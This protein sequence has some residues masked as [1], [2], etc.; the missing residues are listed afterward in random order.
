MLLFVSRFSF[1]EHFLLIYFPPRMPLAV[2]R[3][4][5]YCLL[6]MF[7]SLPS[8]ERA[9]RTTKHGFRV[10]LH[11]CHLHGEFFF[12]SRFAEILVSRT[13]ESHIVRCSRRG[14]RPQHR[15]TIT[16]DAMRWKEENTFSWSKP[17][18]SNRAEILKLVILLSTVSDVAGFLTFQ[19]RDS[20][21]FSVIFAD[22][23]DF[24]S[25]LST[26]ESM[27]NLNALLRFLLAICIIINSCSSISDPQ[28]HNH[29]HEL[30]NFLIVDRLSDNE[31]E[32]RFKWKDLMGK[33]TT[34]DMDGEARY[35]NR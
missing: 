31:K 23:G 10:A 28:Q 22:L 27:S 4:I 26:L 11:D 14:S 20:S 34:L 24:V 17:G 18:I 19:T 32:T 7:F 3:I 2:S 25:F 8:N 15:H 1:R 30:D 5:K 33:E 16:Y 6:S 21:T 29:R 35:A 12:L 9:L 13:I